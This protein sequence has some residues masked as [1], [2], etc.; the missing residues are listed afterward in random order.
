MYSFMCYL[1][2][3][4]TSPLQSKEPNHSE[5]K[6]PRG[7]LIHTQFVW[8]AKEPELRHDPYPGRSP[9]TLFLCCLLFLLCCLLLFLCCIMLHSCVACF[10]LVLRASFLCCMLHSCAACFYSRVACFSWT[11][12]PDLSVFLMYK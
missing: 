9:A 5:N 8:L 2:T 6:L 11:T 12:D 4:A 3:G 1:Q 10:I 7:W